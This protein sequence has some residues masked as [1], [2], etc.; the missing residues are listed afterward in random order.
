MLGE[1][2]GAARSGA[3]PPAADES[4]AKKLCSA[5]EPA[6]WMKGRNSPKVMSGGTSCLEFHKA[7]Y[8]MPITKRKEQQSDAKP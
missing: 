4:R 7:M 2:Q 6:L 3:K 8:S 1:M 5:F